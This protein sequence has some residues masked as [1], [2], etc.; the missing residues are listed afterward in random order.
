MTFTK[1]DAQSNT[2][3]HFFQITLYL[4]YQIHQYYQEI[5]P[6]DAVNS[7]LFLHNANN[8]REL[9]FQR[10]DGKYRRCEINSSYHLNEAVRYYRP[11]MVNSNHEIQSHMCIDLQRCII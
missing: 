7:F 4:A 8:T 3:T 5:F 9:L 11:M 1:T 2:A 6:F 10:A